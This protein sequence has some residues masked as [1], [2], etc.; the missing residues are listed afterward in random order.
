M[1]DPAEEGDL[2][3]LAA[4]LASPPW[5]E[6]HLTHILVSQGPP[7]AQVEAQLRRAAQIA[8]DMDVGA[9]VH[10][11]RGDDVPTAIVDAAARWNCSTMVMS[12]SEEG[13]R[14]AILAAASRASSTMGYLSILVF[15]NRGFQPARRICVPTGGGSHAM[16]GIRFAADLRERWDCELE[17]LRVAR[18][19]QCR[20]DDPVLRR[21]CEQLHADTELQLRMLGIHA[22]VTILPSPAIVAPVVQHAR[23]CDLV[24]L[25]ATNDWRQDEHLAGSIP[26]DIANQVDCSVLM[27]RAGGVDRVAL[28]SIF[29]ENTIR[30]D[31]HPPDKWQ[32]IGML[33]DVLVQERQIPES[34][35]DR[36]LA[37]AFER[38][39]TRPTAM[40]HGA[41]IPHAPILDF[42]GIL[43][44]MAICPDG[45][46]FETR[47]EEPVHF[48]FLLLT[49]QENYRN[50]IPVLSQIASLI[51][52]P[53]VP[54]ALL[55]CETPSEV[56][57]LI[58]RTVRR[59]L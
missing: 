5:G 42:P 12:W 3:R 31:L 33:V 43:G 59:R 45:V 39:R 50:Y 1:Q 37:T 55:E 23:G 24:V 7:V 2:V 58:R 17:I 47:D 46:D 20:W 52:S 19:D 51:R 25:G 35:R 10:L 21:Y 16:L 4:S 13:Q 44:A 56:A 14:E 28:N 15:K 36:V 29:Y 30:L 22:P 34:E 8:L 27:V 32:A 53:T 6:L 41:A 18:D 9:I 57:D 54:A 49:S 26:D 38:E 40:G 48:I 11:E